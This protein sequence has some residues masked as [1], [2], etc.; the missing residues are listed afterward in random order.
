MIEVRLFG[1][2]TQNTAVNIYPITLFYILCAD[3][4]AG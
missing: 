4:V 2:C 1:V 3:C